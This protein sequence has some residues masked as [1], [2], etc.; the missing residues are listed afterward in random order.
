MPKD[1]ANAMIVPLACA[2]HVWLTAAGIGVL[3][4][5]SDVML[6]STQ[7]DASPWS[8]SPF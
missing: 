5:A 2:R 8:D 3:F 6:V 1:M 7:S 4:E